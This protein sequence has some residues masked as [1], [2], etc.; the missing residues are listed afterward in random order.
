VADVDVF[1]EI[2]AKRVFACAVDWPGWCRS[3]RDEPAALEALSA[4]S[5]RYRDALAASGIRPLPPVRPVFLVVQKVKGDATTD[6]GAPSKVANLD[7]RSLSGK[8]ARRLMAILEACWAAFD[9]AARGAGRR[10]LTTGPRGGG[11]QVEAMRAH[12][13]EA[14]RGYLPKVGGSFKPQA[15]STIEFRL[16]GVRGAVLAALEARAS[17]EPAPPSRGKTWPPRYHVRRS[18]WHALDHAWEIAD[19]L[20]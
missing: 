13:L 14:E 16:K 12:V 7:E 17:G 4:Y 20:S 15:G 18:A 1:L 2:G 3:A 9:S 6:F 11:R 5:S 19:R 8:D 10:R